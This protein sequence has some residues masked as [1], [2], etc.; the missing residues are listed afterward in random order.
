M[1]K[2]GEREHT[3]KYPP[4]QPVT[5][6]PIA[7]DIRADPK[8]STTT[9]GIVEKNPPL[10]TPFTSTKIIIGAS[11]V[12]AGQMTS[13]LRAVRVNEMNSVFSEPILSHMIPEPILPTAEEKLNPATRPAPVVGDKPIDVQ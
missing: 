11:V 6:I 3:N 5:I 7:I 1:I 12:E 8:T 2:K 10:D 13:M 9:V 4:A